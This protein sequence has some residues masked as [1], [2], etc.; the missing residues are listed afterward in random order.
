MR[1][2]R[3]A[4]VLICLSLWAMT[5]LAANA[6]FRA[7]TQLLGKSLTLTWQT[8]QAR[9]DLATGWTKQFANSAMLRV[10]ISSKGR[11]LTEKTSYG[12]YNRVARSTKVSDSPDRKEIEWRAEGKSLV[13]YREIGNGMRRMIVDFDKDYQ[14]RSL[15]VI[16]GKPGARKTYFERAPERKFNR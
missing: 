14:T 6:D 5:P 4:T 3:A 13:G 2:R 9:R 15:K 11:I 10:Y 1:T 7:P 8:N 12:E 16:F